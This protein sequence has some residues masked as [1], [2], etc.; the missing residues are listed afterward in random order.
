MNA[1]SDLRAPELARDLPAKISYMLPMAQKPLRYLCTVPP[2]ALELNWKLGEASVTMYDGRARLES[3]SLDQ[4]GFTMIQAPTAMTD[5]Y[6]QDQVLKTYYPEIEQ[7][8]RKATG[9]QKVVVFDYNCRSGSKEDRQRTGA[10]PPARFV[11]ADYTV[12]SAPQRVRD[13]LPAAE[14]ETRLR[15]RYVFIN[16]WRPIKGPIQ[17]DTLSLCDAQSV[18]SNDLVATDL[19]YS[20]R[21]GEFYNV[22]FNANHRWHYFRHLETSEVLVFV[23]FDSR[24][25]K[26]VPHVAFDDATAA[27]NAPPRESIEVRTIAFF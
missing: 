25:R 9:A 20:D 14:A 12:K 17:N 3:L 8:V 2:G 22:T 27:P 23:N 7:L 11:H 15:G 26:V 19:I 4:Q 10:F 18:A 5:F 24:E 6:D 16:V 1:I 13:L 21:Q